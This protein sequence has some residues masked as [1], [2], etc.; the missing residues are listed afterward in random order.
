[1]RKRI[2]VVFERGAHLM[3][4]PKGSNFFLKWGWV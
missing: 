4:F 3:D 1:M 2:L